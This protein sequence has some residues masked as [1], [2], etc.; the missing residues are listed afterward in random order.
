MTD[1]QPRFTDITQFLDLLQGVKSSGDGRWTSLCP[2]HNDTNPSLG[3]RFNKQRIGL[4]C[5]AGCETR[6]VCE[7]LNISMADLDLSSEKPKHKTRTEKFDRSTPDVTY[8]YTDEQGKLVFQVCRYQLGGKRKTFLQRRPDG[9]GGWI[10]SVKDIDLPLYH[11]PEIIL[12]RQQGKVVYL[13]EGEKDSDALRQIGATATTNAMGAAKWRDNYTEF[14][15]DCNVV[16]IPDKDDAGAGHLEVVSKVLQGVA[17]RIRIMPMPGDAKDPADWIAE[18]HNKGELESITLA[19]LD[20]S[21]ELVAGFVSQYRHTL[22]EIMVTNRHM[23]EVTE[24]ALTILQRQNKPT[25]IFRRSDILTRVTR[26]ETDRPYTDELKEAAFRGELD[27]CCN[28]VRL[29]QSGDTIPIP[30]PLEVVRDG[31][32]RPSDWQ[33][34]ALLGII[35]A[36]V[37]RPD[38]TILDKP[39]YD[40]ATKL[41]YYPTPGLEVPAIPEKCNDSHL[42]DA[43]NLLIEPI[44]DFPFDS[45]ASWCNAIGTMIAPILRPMITGPVPMV[46]LD[47][48]QQGTGATL[49]AETISTIA[50]GRPAAMMTAPDDDE[51]WRKAITSLLMKGQMVCTVDN[52]EGDLWAPSL[53]AVLTSMTWQDRILGGNKMVELPHRAIWIATG[54]NIH[55]RGDLP[56]RCFWCRMDAGVA[57][58]WMRKASLFRHPDLRGWIIDNRGAIL[59]AILILA[60]EWTRANKPVADEIPILGGYESYCSIINGVLGFIGAVDFMGNLDRMYDET[61][62]ETPE[63]EGFF[64][65]WHDILKEEAY[66]TA[67]IIGHIND[68]DELRNALPSELAY[69]MEGR[70][71]KF[72]EAKNPGVRLGQ[73]LSKRIGTKYM[74]NCVLQKAGTK[75][76]AVTWQV[77]RVESVATTSLKFSLGSEVREVGLTPTC[78]KENNS[79][80]NIC[81]GAGGETTSP[82]SPLATK[83]SEVANKNTPK[84]ETKKVTKITLK[85]I[86]EGKLGNGD[87]PYPTHPCRCGGTEFWIPPKG[88][89]AFK[90]GRQWQ[91]NNCHHSPDPSWVV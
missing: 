20:Y 16:I 82:T 36:P 51:G 44:Q 38:G 32:T 28:F 14:L 8:D 27:R 66:T 83:T 12:A 26:D 65:A 53:A 6:K 42:Q 24:E 49:L 78:G 88:A 90:D 57:R 72:G 89:K 11:L 46:L 35:E 58:P 40:E 52:I 31:L 54:N 50:T 22:P 85:V 25:R 68:F 59:A 21:P 80:I 45:K 69:I 86:S 77:V 7:A 74:N 23:R 76:R 60:R 61:D 63:W 64:G 91:C 70:K 79:D 67:E 9:A 33:F 15:R 87:P 41:F 5:F 10:W 47:K 2:S 19:A 17:G 75:Q 1:K 29:S 71:G 3:I 62:R 56:R 43:R 30:P 55:L 39:G 34:P 84:N 18:G 81:I 48:P 13:T 4:Y 73:R 37:L